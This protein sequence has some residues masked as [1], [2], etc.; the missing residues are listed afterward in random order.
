MPHIFD[1]LHNSI[2]Y[3]KHRLLGRTKNVEDARQA[4]SNLSNSEKDFVRHFVDLLANAYDYS[5]KDKPDMLIKK[6][7]LGAQFA[8]QFLPNISFLMENREL[9]FN[10]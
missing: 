8:T 4:F 10:Q 9:I 5:W 7:L 2:L 3:H 1:W 6:M